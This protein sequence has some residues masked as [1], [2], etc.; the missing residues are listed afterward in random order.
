MGISDRTR[1]CV[2]HRWG[3][4]C[5]LGVDGGRGRVEG[6]GKWD[7]R[8]LFLSLLSV[9]VNLSLS[10][11]WY[12]LLGNELGNELG[13]DHTYLR[14]LQTLTYYVSVLS[15]VPVKV[16]NFSFISTYFQLLMSVN[17]ILWF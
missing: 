5:S 12:N 17:Y 7:C 10:T 1:C 3:L 14:F 11:K 13:N 16:I 15:F 2:V 6:R 4:T 9:K 8:I